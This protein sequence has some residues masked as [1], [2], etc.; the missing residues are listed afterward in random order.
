[1]LKHWFSALDSGSRRAGVADSYQL[2]ATGW[3]WPVGNAKTPYLGHITND[4]VYDRLPPGVLAKVQELNPTQETTKRRK[5][6]HHQFL[7][8]DV[9][10]PDLRDHLLQIIPLMKIS[11]DWRT[12]ER[13]LDIAFPK[14]GTQIEM[15]VA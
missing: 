6:K 12:F 4:I 8:N 3:K 2:S 7:S 5:W 13:H 15:D 11:K 10:Q 1:M 14:S 9:G